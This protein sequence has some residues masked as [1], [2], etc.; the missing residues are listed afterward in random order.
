VLQPLMRRKIE[1]FLA[2]LPVRIQAGLDSPRW[3][4]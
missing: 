1:Q 3:S 2:D 4:A